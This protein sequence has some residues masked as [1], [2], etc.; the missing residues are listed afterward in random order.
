MLGGL[1]GKSTARLFGN[2]ISN[3]LQALAEREGFE[4]SIRF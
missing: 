4:P 1:W 3:L 2:Y